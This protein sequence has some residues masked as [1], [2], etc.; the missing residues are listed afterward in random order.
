MFIEPEDLVGKPFFFKVK[1]ESGKINENYTDCFVE[2]TLKVNE[3]DKETFRTEVVRIPL[4]SA[5]HLLK[6]LF[7][8]TRGCIS[9]PASMTPSKTTSRSPM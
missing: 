8:I 1:I 6:P 4:F 9:S 5:N 7:G 2:Y 3:I